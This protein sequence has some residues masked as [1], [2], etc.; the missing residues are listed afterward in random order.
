MHT[1]L[2]PAC[3]QSVLF[4]MGKPFLVLSFPSDG[5]E[6]TGD[7]EEACTHALSFRLG[8]YRHPRERTG[9]TKAEKLPEKEKRHKPRRTDKKETRASQAKTEKKANHR[10][11][12]LEA[13]KKEK[14][15]ETV[16]VTT[17]E[18][19]SEATGKEAPRQRG[20][21]EARERQQKKGSKMREKAPKARPLQNNK[22][23]EEKEARE[24]EKQ[25]TKVRIELRSARVVPLPLTR[26]LSRL[27]T[28]SSLEKS[29]REVPC[30]LFS[31]L[32]F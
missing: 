9:Q 12:L 21:K 28:D 17:R 18:E 16:R 2:L 31:T 5:E 15:V 3:A 14:R 11:P 24:K 32:F 4:A 23:K 7:I 6:D 22:R 8:L 29:P 20:Q 30:F 27:V 1:S 10:N 13:R 19:R 25:K 26:V